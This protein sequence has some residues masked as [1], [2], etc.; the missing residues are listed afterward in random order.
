MHEESTPPH[1]ADR[2]YTV[3]LCALLAVSA[4]G[5]WF[6]IHIEHGKFS[7]DLGLPDV[8]LAGLMLLLCECVNRTKASW[9][10]RSGAMILGA[11]LPVLILVLQCLTR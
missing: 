10:L 4:W 6:I 7:I 2:T 8:I 5:L 3:V 1:E 9:K 11:S